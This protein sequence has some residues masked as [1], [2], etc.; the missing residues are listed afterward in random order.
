VIWKDSESIR[1]ARAG[2][3]VACVD[4]KAANASMFGV[5]WLEIPGTCVCIELNAKNSFGGYTG[6]TRT[7]AMWQDDGAF[8]VLDGG[9]AGYQ[10]YC[11]GL[12]PFPQLNGN[13]VPPKK[14]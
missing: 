7:V 12:K 6:I 13:Y 4:K 8:K 14:R 3:P 11:Q 5:Q 2:E 9:T 10:Q 1:D